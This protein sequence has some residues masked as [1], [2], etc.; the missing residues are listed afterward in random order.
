MKNLLFINHLI[1]GDFENLKWWML[2][3]AIMAMLV[4]I[5]SVIDL[6]YGILASKAAGI[7]QTTSYGLR[8][9]VDKDKGYLTF[10]AFGVLID[11]CLS[12]F[13]AIPVSCAVVAIG[14]ILIE[15]VSV[16]ENRK[17]ARIN[18]SSNPL[19]VAKAV[20][21]TFGISDAQKIEEIIT[22]IKDSK[23]KEGT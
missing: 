19:D 5:S 2:A 12:F 1:T 23:N 3:I 14:E 22:Y 15:G 18:D 4:I 13:C 6:Y 9:T 17:R 8:K 7:F 20:I 11:S 10:Y 16:M 21:K